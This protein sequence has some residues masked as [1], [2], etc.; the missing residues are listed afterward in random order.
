MIPPPKARKTS[1][2]RAV[3]SNFARNSIGVVFSDWGSA[4]FSVL[5][6]QAEIPEVRIR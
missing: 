2:A 3:V 6:V 1:P 4:I 5:A